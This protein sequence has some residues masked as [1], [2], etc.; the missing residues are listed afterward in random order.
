[1]LMILL[2]SA[3]LRNAFGGKLAEAWEIK[4]PQSGDFTRAFDHNDRVSSL[5]VTAGG[6][7][8]SERGFD[9]ATIPTR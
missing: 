8:S 1:M 5:P 9:I 7:H 4:R 2:R 6:A 3:F